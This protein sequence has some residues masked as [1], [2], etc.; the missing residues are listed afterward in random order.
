MKI[1]YSDKS[2]TAW[3]GM[4]EMKRLIDKSN[5]RKALESIGLPES[6]SNNSICVIDIVESFMVSVW[7]GCYKFSHTAVV[8]LDETLKKIFGWERIPS[9]TTYGRFFQKFNIEK[10]TEVF[11]KLNTWFFNQLQF[12]N[13]TLDVDSSVF[14]RYGEQ[15]GAEKGYNPTKRGRKSHHPL[16]AF[17]SGIRMVANCWL[18]SGATSS[19][20]NIL[21]FLDETMRILE[22]KKIGLLRGDSG[23]FSNM[24]LEKLE[25]KLIQYVIAAKMHYRLQESIAGIQAWV[26]LDKNLWIA[27]TQYKAQKWDTVRRIVVIRQSKILNENSTGKQLTLYAEDAAYYNFKYHSFVTNQELPAQE[28][29]EQ[30]KRRGDAENRIKELKDDFGVE[31]F[32]MDSFYGTEATMKMITVAYNM[33]SL[34]RQVTGQTTVHP[35]LTTLRFNCFAVG[36]WIVKKGNSNVL[37]MAVPLK[38]RKW[39]DGLFSGI[40]KTDLPLSLTVT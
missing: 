4:I 33:M 12:D 32:N 28:I 6:L 5:L 31:G 16:F 14:T 18:R 29:W 21:A 2:V 27:E 22:N 23:F 13:Y 19:S 9:G 25:S 39:Y 3:G 10:N 8:R 35:R 24:I 26:Q 37:K 38:R 15:E 30:Y 20:N 40:N 36:S 1:A 34:F 7:I 17:V 11:V